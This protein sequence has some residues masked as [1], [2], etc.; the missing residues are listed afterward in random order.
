MPD[1]R[2][3]PHTAA[4]TRKEL[5]VFVTEKGRVGAIMLVASS[6]V[7]I[8]GVPTANQGRFVGIKTGQWGVYGSTGQWKTPALWSGQP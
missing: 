2:T 1:L 7:G 4:S 5:R 8:F 3:T 6:V